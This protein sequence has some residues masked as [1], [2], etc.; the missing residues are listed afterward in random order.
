MSALAFKKRRSDIVEIRGTGNASVD[1][2]ALQAAV[3]TANANAVPVTFHVSGSVYI[4]AKV[5]ITCPISWTAATGGELVRAT[6]AGQL[7][8]GSESAPWDEGQSYDFPGTAVG[9]SYLNVTANTISLNAGDYVAIW[10]QNEVGTPDFTPHS[11]NSRF[12]PL[13]IHRLSR[14]V[15][16]SST[17]MP[18]GTR[19]VFNDFCDDACS[20][21]PRIRKLSM[22]VGIRMIGVTC[23]ALP[24][25]FLD[26]PFV[27]FG[28]CADVE[29]RDCTFGP[30]N[31]G[32][33]AFWCCYNVRRINCNFGDVENPNTNLM[34]ANGGAYATIDRV[35]TRSEVLNCRFGAVR[36]GYTTGAAV[37]KWVAGRAVFANEL[38]SHSGR[39][40]R[41]GSTGTTG[42]T[43]PTHT[44]SS[45]SDGTITWTYISTGDYR[46]GTV[47]GFRVANC[48][49]GANGVQT[50]AVS[51]GNPGN[52]TGTW[53]GLSPFDV[54]AEAIRGTFEN[55]QARIPNETGN[56][57]FT[58]RGRYIV[59]SNNTVYGGSQTIPVQM[60]SSNCTVVGN[61]FIGGHRCEIIDKEAVNPNLKNVRF[62]GNRFIDFYNPGLI[63]Y[64]GQDHLINDNDFINCG[65][66]FNNSPNIPSS[67]LYLKAASGL[68][69][70]NNR[71]GKYANKLS[72][73]WDDGSAGPFN[74][75]VENNVM[76]GYGDW[77][78]GTRHAS[79]R[80]SVSI[81]RYDMVWVED[82][83]YRVSSIVD[84]NNN[85]L[86]SGTTGLVAPT[87]YVGSA[88]LSNITYQFVRTLTTWNYG[89]AARKFMPQ[90]GFG[91]VSVV[92]ISAHGLTNADRYRP[93]N[94]DG[95][96]LDNLSQPKCNMVLLDVVN[97]DTLIV[98][99]SGDQ[100][101]FISY[102]VNNSF[103]MSQPVDL[104]WDVANLDYKTTAPQNNGA[105]P[106]IRALYQDFDKVRILVL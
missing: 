28:Y 27:Q 83:E 79:W 67:A 68:R 87:H 59:I 55:N 12:L 51:N 84:N 4:N 70:T 31:P 48:V 22:I 85:Q 90:N 10:S 63:V 52:A 40:Y 39:V 11:A 100:V 23:R 74:M 35:V 19:F 18:A 72:I 3:A 53:S 97:D 33:L 106:M 61:T 30:L 82:R 103:S 101:D 8:Y 99:Y 73:M 91:H 44:S 9:D 93:I 49:A 37:R 43:A 41:A 32:H 16:G 75:T 98:A 34:T 105:D 36:H 92:T 38:R 21:Y 60:Q 94:D 64:N 89:L 58:I 14:V 54:H 62:I 6:T 5:T 71:L 17:A 46:T 7:V 81:N 15:E 66:L 20:T 77:N 25:A 69:V 65:Y 29:V 56:I 24:G 80:A 76:S 57:G 13:E 102:S 50:A 42:N 26:N 104:Y 45:A 95:T 88:T 2:P 86:T 1:T 47:R 78:D 96:V